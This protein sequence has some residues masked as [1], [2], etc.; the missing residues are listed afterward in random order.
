M[1]SQEVWLDSNR[2]PKITRP[3]YQKTKKLRNSCNIEKKKAEIIM[4]SRNS[5]IKNEDYYLIDKN[6]EDYFVA[7]IKDV[8]DENDNI[9]LFREDYKTLYNNKWLT[10]F[11][12]DYC[13]HL[14]I[15][16][17]SKQD[18]V[19]YI[20][21]EVSTILLNGCKKVLDYFF[22]NLKKIMENKKE[23]FLPVNKDQAHWA[24]VYVNSSDGAFYYLS[25]SDKD[26]DCSFYFQNFVDCYGRIFSEDDVNWSMKTIKYPCQN[27]SFNCG[28]YVLHYMKEILGDNKIIINDLNP[29]EFRKKLDCI[30]KSLDVL[31]RCLVCGQGESRNEQHWIC[32]D[33]CL[34][35]SY[36]KCTD[37]KN[38]KLQ[39]IQK[40]GFNFDCD[41]C[42][43]WLFNK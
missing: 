30:N 12:I 33:T 16:E 28:I 34:R 13:S 19:A 10:N 3:S 40:E 7:Y 27:D 18:R 11:I 35:W 5:T 9:Y 37:H 41:L 2:Q 39:E 32:C 8:N 23:F 20:F 4:N 29:N 38:K 26:D 22:I 17:S 24:L 1:M 42:H 21:C 43:Y 6:K 25:S 36:L 31:N 15:L 14:L